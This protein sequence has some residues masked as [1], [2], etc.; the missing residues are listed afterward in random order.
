MKL[1]QSFINNS[2]RS[3]ITDVCIPYDASWNT[4]R[5][6][7]EFELFRDIYKGKHSNEPWGL[8]S[9]KFEHKTCVPVTVFKTFCGSKLND[10]Y[11]CVFINPMIANEAVYLNVWEQAEHCGHKGMAKIAQ[12]LQ[13]HAGINTAGHMG[14][15]SFSFC[16]F[17][18]GT[19]IFW[20][21]YFAFIDKA[22]SE[23]NTQAQ[24]GTEV[25]VAF[26]NSGH[27]KR[28]QSA[29]MK[30][31]VIERLFSS[32]VISCPEIKCSAFTYSK[33]IY[34]RKFGDKLGAL[35]YRLSFVK[36]HAL[37]TRDIELL[38]L[39]NDT[40]LG[41]INDSYVYAIWNMDDPSA[42]Y[43]GEQYAKFSKHL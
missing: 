39:W 23:L 8:I 41:L 34:I 32:F 27:Y 9:W 25:G 21:A 33:D 38:N 5:D 37:A 3:H 13:E 28:D 2:Q 6:A 30:V 14:K 26:S 40:R 20:E 36:N 4:K 31:F 16:N 10:G 11:D 15:V 29:T 12:H 7:R 43:L 24:S 42:F 19:Q 1:Y 18:V 22:I 17:F 35:L